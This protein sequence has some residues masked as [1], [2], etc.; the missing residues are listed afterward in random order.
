[1]TAALVLITYAMVFS[2]GEVTI[3][4]SPYQKSL[5]PALTQHGLRLEIGKCPHLRWTRRRHHGR[6]FTLH[7]GNLSDGSQQYLSVDRD[8]ER[9]ILTR[10]RSV[11]SEWCK[12]FIPQTGGYYVL[13]SGFNFKYVT[14]NDDEARLV[15]SLAN[16]SMVNMKRQMR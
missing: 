2:N 3:R 6:F 5:H 15:S 13:Q 7:A 16:A 9:V 8:G 10:D 11:R 12:E 1:M 14:I 4:F